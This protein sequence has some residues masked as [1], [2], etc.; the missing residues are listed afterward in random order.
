[1]FV[2]PAERGRGVARLL[3]ADLEQRARGLGVRLLRL[4]TRADLVEA[5]TLYASV[6]FEHVPA[7]NEGP[8]REVWLAKPLDPPLSG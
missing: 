2:V 4:D 8:F 7:F 5:L 6:G 1:V 3:L